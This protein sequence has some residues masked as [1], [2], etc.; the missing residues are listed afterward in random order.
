[1]QNGNGG[2]AGG[3]ASVELHGDQMRNCGKVAARNV[4][5]AVASTAGAT[6]QER[7]ANFLADA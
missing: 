7:S 1:M 6:H 4:A 2:K 5:L 3:K